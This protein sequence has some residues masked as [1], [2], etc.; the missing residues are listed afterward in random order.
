MVTKVCFNVEN[1][2]TACV[3][4]GGYNYLYSADIL[5]DIDGLVA[6]E[7]RWLLCKYIVWL[8]TAE[9][10]KDLPYDLQRD[11]ELAH[12]SISQWMNELQEILDNIQRYPDAVIVCV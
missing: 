8:D 2:C 10:A 3:L 7:A 6:A 11:I 5:D 9:W 4:M 1:E 12:Q